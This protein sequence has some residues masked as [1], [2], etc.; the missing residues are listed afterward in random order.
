MFEGINILGFVDQ[1]KTDEDCKKYLYGLK[2]QA[3]FVCKKC[4]NRSWCRTN[5]PYVRKCNRCKHKESATAGTLF[6]KCKFSLRKSFMI[7]YYMSTTKKSVSSHELS[8]QLN[9]RQKTCWLFQQK[10]RQAM[11]S[12][13]EDFLVKLDKNVAVDEFLVGGQEK[14]KRGRSKG[15]KKEVVIAIKYNDY[16]IYSCYAQKIKNCGTK[17]LRPF[18]EDHIEKQAVIK[19]DK[20]RGYI[21]LEKE[22]PNLYHVPSKKGKNFPFIHRQIMMLKGWLRGIHHHCTHLQHY[23]DEY[24]YRFNRNGNTQNIFHDLVSRL[25][26]SQP[27]TYK[28]FKLLWG[29]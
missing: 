13:E 4:G 23:L 12:K 2:W 17:Q 6:H 1:F 25:M 28:K 8:R 10:V 27:M 11:G 20:W 19:S 9:L 7:I 14:G 5:D 24:C 21:P 16:G 26:N 18:F 22:Y 29:M 3:G 15:K